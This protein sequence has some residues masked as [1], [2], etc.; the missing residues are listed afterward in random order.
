MQVLTV[1]CHPRRN[2]LTHAVAERFRVGLR[3]AGHAGDLADLY[4]ERFDPLMEP[5]D[6]P[7][8]D[9]DRKR[10]TDAVL[11]EQARI[12]RHQ[13]IAM[14][15]PVWWWSVPAM[16]KGWIDRVWNNGWAYGSRKLALK[17]GL[18]IGVAAG[19][20]ETYDGARGYRPAMET[21]LVQ[22]VLD[23]CGIADGRLELLMDSLGDDR[24][25]AKL[26]DRA[27]ALGRSFADGLL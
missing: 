9:D 22:G 10:Y 18:L 21:Q 12:E 11:A 2:S 8:W 20:A 26:L 23:Y 5:P 13:A 1:L 16:L 15:F 25:R 4:D 17:R 24:T 3:Q 7:D 19:G 27:E 6:E 14:V